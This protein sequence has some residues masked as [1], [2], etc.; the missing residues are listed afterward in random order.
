MSLY[1]PLSKGTPDVAVDVR[2]MGTDHFVCKAPWRRAKAA[3]DS[4]QPTGDE[5]VRL[6]FRAIGPQRC[7]RLIGEQFDLQTG[8]VGRAGVIAAHRGGPGLTLQ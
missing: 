8:I 2:Q 1:V 3:C 6:A 4:P 7:H 5:L